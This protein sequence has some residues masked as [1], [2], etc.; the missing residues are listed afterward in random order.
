[1]DITPPQKYTFHAI[2]KTHWGPY[3]KIVSPLEE[4]ETYLKEEWGKF[5]PES[6][7]LFLDNPKTSEPERLRSKVG[8]LVSQKLSPSK[9]FFYK[10]ISQTYLKLSF[11]GAPSIGPYKVYGRA[12]EWFQKNP[13]YQWS[14]PVLEV[15]NI[16]ENEMITFFYFSVTKKIY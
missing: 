16:K 3:H 11:K 6:F 4:V 5:C 14:Y 15:Y 2:Y 13:S 10:K 1:M 7:A 9:P 12:M 8:C